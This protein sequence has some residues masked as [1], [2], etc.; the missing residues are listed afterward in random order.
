MKIKS[1]LLAV[2]ILLLCLNANSQEVINP[3]KLDILLLKPGIYFIKFRN[4]T[5]IFVKE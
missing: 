3:P 5:N 1:S 2:I 4:F